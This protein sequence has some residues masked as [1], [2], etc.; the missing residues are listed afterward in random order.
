MKCI[1]MPASHSH[2]DLGPSQEQG[3]VGAVLSG[4]DGHGLLSA[5]DVHTVDLT[6]THTHTAGEREEV[7]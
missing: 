7:S 2:L 3:D 1:P 4:E 5:L 6:H